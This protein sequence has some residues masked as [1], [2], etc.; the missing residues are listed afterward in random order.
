MKRIIVI[1]LI[2][3]CFSFASENL[4]SLELSMLG[5]VRQA[6]TNS[7]FFDNDPPGTIDES[8]DSYF[9]GF[10]IKP[11]LSFFYHHTGL[12]F[13]VDKPF[14]D[15][16]FKRYFILSCGLKQR[17]SLSDKS[18]LDLYLGTT[19]HTVDDAIQ[20]FIDFFMATHFKSELGLDVGTSFNYE[21][22]KKIALYTEVNYNYNAHY[23]DKPEPITITKR[24]F[25]TLSLNIGVV[26]SLF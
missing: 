3:T 11:G 17:I 14:F 26:F 7:L 6:Y 24:N 10:A 5:G 20:S 23:T 9:F 22:S 4:F 25:Q 1:S 18:A 16:R 13:S 15:Y 2:L 21:L 19:W 12:Y 8:N